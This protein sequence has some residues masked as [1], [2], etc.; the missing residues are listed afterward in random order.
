MLFAMTWIDLEITILSEVRERQT[1]YGITY[2]WNLFFFFFIQIF[3]WKEIH[4]E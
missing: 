1:S 4:L 3:N 2:M